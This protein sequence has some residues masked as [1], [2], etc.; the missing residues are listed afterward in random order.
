MNEERSEVEKK[1][2]HPPRGVAAKKNRGSRH[3]EAIRMQAVK[4]V[5][6]EGFSH[7]LVCE[8]LGVPAS[9]LSGWLQR[10]RQFGES[11]LR[12]PK[13]AAASSD[14]LPPPVTEQIVELKKQ[15]PTFGAKRISQWLRRVFLMPGSAET[16]RQR[17]H[18]AGLMV[19]KPPASKQRNMTRPRFFERATP[20]Q[21]WQSDIFTFRLGGRYAY[22]V[23]F[24]DDYSRFI[25]A[26]DLFRSPTAHAVIEVYRQAVGEYQPP[27]EMLTDNGRQYT[28]WR[29]VS[30]FEAELKK[31][32]VSHFKSRPQH[33]MTLGK[34]ERFWETIWQEFL[35]RAQ[36]ESFE[37]ARERI[38]LWLKYYNHKRPHQGIEGLCPA[39]RFF[40]IQNELRKTIEAGIKENVLEMALRGQPR[41]PF[42]MVG[43][44]EGQ[45]VVLH[46]EKGKLKLSVSDNQN[47]KE[48]VYDLNQQSSG[49]AQQP[50][51]PDQTPK[52]PAPT[53]ASERDR[54]S[55]GGTGGLD[56]VLHRFG[57][58]PP[59]Q[60]QLDDA[61]PVAGPGDGGNAPGTGTAS[62]TLPGQSSE[63][64]PAGSASETL[65]GCQQDLQ[66]PGAAPTEQDCQSPA[67]YGKSS[68]LNE[69]NPPS[70]ESQATRCS[71]PQSTV[72][73]VD[74]YGRGPDPGHLPPGLL[75]V[76][77]AGPQ[78]D[79]QCV[80]GTTSGPA[81]PAPRSGQAGAPKASGAAPQTTPTP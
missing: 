51:A 35:S 81:A 63:S 28:T 24:M 40:E 54:E 22:L 79:A 74:G 60:H 19:G 48:L 56:R 65:P 12:S 13:P 27:K 38:K 34:I 5:C 52:A 30:R 57:H 50:N 49:K 23:A 44:M 33:P 78:S 29:G 75:P 41:A 18:R 7:A 71:D 6:E 42:Y 73:P 36:F 9:T 72:G 80:A 26:A 14:K 45:S 76:G 55:A 46:A 37:T 58:L 47:Q 68:A 21:M 64:A 32:R 77:A 11:A 61:Q 53:P 31:D 43:R 66:P 3:P 39:D 69:S 62:Q 10:Y 25:T 16:V 70:P 67:R 15:N 59:V 17:L 1:N 8:Q 2:P 4:L 20:N